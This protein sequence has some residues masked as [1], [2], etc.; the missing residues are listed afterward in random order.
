M[1][2]LIIRILGND[3]P[4][5]H[6]SNQTLNNLKFTLENESKFPNTDKIYLLNRIYDNKKRTNIINLLKKYNNKFVEI[7]FKLD[8]Y[9]NINYNN[10]IDILIKENLRNKKLLELIKEHNLY[11]INN[12]GSRNYCIDYGKKN[13]YDWIF[14]LDSN[15][16]FTDKYFNKILNVIN[17]KNKIDYLVI[18]QIRIKDLNIQNKEIFLNEDK[19]EKLKI[20]EP[21]IAF[22]KN[23]KLLFNENIPYGFC[24]KAEFLRMIKVSGRWNNWK[25]N[26]KYYNI[27]DREKQIVN[28]KIISKVIRLNPQEK[29]NGNN[30]FNR[31]IKGLYN[32]I[33]LIRNKNIKMEHFSNKNKINKK[34]YLLYLLLFLAILIILIKKKFIRC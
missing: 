22:N 20:N 14:P 4:S 17:K 33:K 21:Q 2:L 34:N 10:Q 5:I 13:N 11:L 23:S 1:K 29:Y 30:N 3:L 27:K 19:L 7:P 9:L 26:Y 24:P 6:G 16:F 25:D 18:P 28:Y 8:D 32:L 15:S 31:R 12:N